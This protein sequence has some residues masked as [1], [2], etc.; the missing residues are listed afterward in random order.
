MFKNVQLCPQKQIVIF[1]VH[2]QFTFA[3]FAK[4]IDI[5]YATNLIESVPKQLQNIR[6]NFENISEISVNGSKEWGIEFRFK[7]K[8][9][10]W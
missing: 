6:H 8:R 10:V 9:F 4:N 2:C 5:G 7:D 1:S 3:I